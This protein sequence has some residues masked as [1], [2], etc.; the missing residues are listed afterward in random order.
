MRRVPADPA[1]AARPSTALQPRAWR[2]RLLKLLTL[3]CAPLAVPA[4][5]LRTGDR[6]PAFTL[7]ASTGGRVSLADF[8]GRKAVVLFFY[9]A[10][11]TGL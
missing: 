2:R 3:A 4:W 11:F 9:P 10:A 5:A 6:A 7:P 1:G 8:A